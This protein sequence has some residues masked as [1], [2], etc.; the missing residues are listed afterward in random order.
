MGELHS[1]ARVLRPAL[2][3]IRVSAGLLNLRGGGGQRR[4]SSVRASLACLLVSAAWAVLA[5]ALAPQAGAQTIT[6]TPFR[7]VTLYQ[8]TET[9]P[10]PLKIDVIEIDLNDPAIQFRMTPSNGG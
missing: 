5:P 9:S 10:R 1:Q 6:T 3:T 8:R 4:M 2:S 7:G